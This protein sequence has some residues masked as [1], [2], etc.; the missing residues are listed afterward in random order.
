MAVGI[1]RSTA[2]VDTIQLVCIEKN[3]RNIHSSR[4]DTADVL[5]SLGVIYSFFFNYQRDSLLKDV[6]RA[7]ASR[8]NNFIPDF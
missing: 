1:Y 3:P 5:L 4:P 2:L 6:V 8:I 7:E